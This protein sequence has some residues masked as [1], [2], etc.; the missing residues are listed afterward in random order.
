VNPVSSTG[1]FADDA[2]HG[3][4]EMVENVRLARDTFRVRFECP[5]IARRIVPGQFLMLRLAGCDDPLLGRPL[6]LYDTV[7]NERGEPARLD[8]VYLV[9]GKLTRRLSQLGPGAR[10][11][12][13]GPLGNGFDPRPAEHLVMVA[14]GI[15]QTPFLALAREALGQ[16][17]YGS[18]PRQPAVAKEVT[19]LYGARTRELLAGVEDFQRLGVDVHVSTDDGTAGH[20][21]FVTDLLRQFLAQADNAPLPKKMTNDG[22]TNDEFELELATRHSSFRHSVMRHSYRLVCCGP[23]PMMHA[24]AEIAAAAGAPCQVSLE[25]PMACGIGACFSCVAKV[26]DDQGGW[27]YRR[28]CVE[29]PVFDADRIIF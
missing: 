8:I 2:W 14:G 17:R 28:T 4:V 11:E 13:W 12:V 29:G 22:M 20:H 3:G 16:R 24:V 6:A 26:R 19:L 7:L 15:G 18:P 9:V 25:S 23:E 5:E 1:C 27:D 21:G 10:L